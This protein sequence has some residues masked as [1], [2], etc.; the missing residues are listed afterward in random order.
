[1]AFVGRSLSAPPQAQAQAAGTL[2]Q[3]RRPPATSVDWGQ[4]IAAAAEAA[5]LVIIITTLA[6]VTNRSK[7]VRPAKST[8]REI[9]CR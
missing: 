5:K 9:V 2:R 4:I 6:L 7:S 8:K 3:A 1:L